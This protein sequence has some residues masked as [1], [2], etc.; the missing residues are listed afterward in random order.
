VSLIEKLI[1]KN[2]E[3]SSQNIEP[4]TI[5]LSRFSVSIILYIKKTKKIMIYIYPASEKV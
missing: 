4:N 3:L 2:L 5:I 1:W